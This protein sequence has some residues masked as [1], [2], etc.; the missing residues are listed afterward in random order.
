MTKQVTLA[1][2]ELR[3]TI[4]G[5]EIIKGISFELHEGEVFGFL[6]PNGAGKTTTI[7]MLVGLIRPT[8]G[9]VVICGYDLHRQFTDAIR[10]IGCIV[11]NPEM[12]PYLTGWENL[13]HF[14][15]M[16]PGIGADRIMEVAKL[17][18]LEQRIHDRV[19]TYSLGMRQRLGIAQAL[20]GKPKVL[21]LDE[22]TNGLDP[23]GIREMR[24]FIRFLA[25]TEGLSV[26][27]SSHLLSEIQLMCDRVAI[28]AKGRLLAVD[29]VERLLN[30][31]A[32]VVWK[33]A[34]TDRARALLAAETEVLRADEETIV[35]PY[36]PSRLAAWNAKLVQAGVSVPEIEPRL[37]TLE[38][39]FIELT[40]GE[41]I[42]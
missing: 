3:K 22:P 39:L 26:L 30:Q 28:M 27:V 6:G 17:V 12:Y 23:A 18:G 42:E 14:A 8:S 11:E 9:T 15:R 37:P 34:P 33:A 10:Q 21:I 29:T 25:E 40:G 38:D 2:K 1:V 36:E 16:I 24:A 20:L 5:K 13:E 4:R 35:T 19:G 41:T 31:Q 32:R 7:R